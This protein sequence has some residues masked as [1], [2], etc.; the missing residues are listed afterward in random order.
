MRTTRDA[1]RRTDRRAPG[2]AGRGARHARRA[3]VSSSRRTWR[4][5]PM[6][7]AR[8][9]WR[10]SWE[11][12]PAKIYQAATASVRARRRTSSVTVRSGRSRHH[13]RSGARPLGRKMNNCAPSRRATRILSFAQRS[14]DSR[15]QGHFDPSAPPRSRLAAVLQRAAASRGTGGGRVAAARLG[16]HR[17]PTGPSVAPTSHARDIRR[18]IDVVE[19]ALPAGGDAGDAAVGHVRTVDRS[20]A[21]P[22]GRGRAR[23]RQAV[24]RTPVATSKNTIRWLRAAGPA[25]LAAALAAHDADGRPDRRRASRRRHRSP[26]RR[27]VRGT[28]M[29]AVEGSKV[30]ALAAQRILHDFF[31]A[32]EIVE[33]VSRHCL[34]EPT[35]EHAPG[36]RGSP[37]GARCRCGRSVGAARSGRSGL[38]IVEAR[39]ELDLEDLFTLVQKQILYRDVITFPAPAAGGSR[40]H[41]RRQSAAASCSRRPRGGRRGAAGGTVPQ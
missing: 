39:F 17:G 14:L 10:A 41:R 24:R 13:T 1:R 28:R 9:S 34:V 33:A 18:D 26:R 7:S 11:A 23:R 40:V 36:L 27:A 6:P 35:F 4:R 22:P 3:R 20:A 16:F 2:A 32:E 21:A 29:P 37:I 19:V 8:S 30:A 25:Q 12:K 38:P 31:Q 5:S 15:E